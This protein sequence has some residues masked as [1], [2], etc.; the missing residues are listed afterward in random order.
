MAQMIIAREVRTAI[1]H[2][3]VGEARMVHVV[4]GALEKP[5]QEGMQ[6]VAAGTSMEEI[7][8]EYAHHFFS[9]SITSS[10]IKLAIIDWCDEQT[11][12]GGLKNVASRLKG[13]KLPFYPE[14]D[15]ISEIMIEW[16]RR[17][18][19]LVNNLGQAY[20]KASR[21]DPDLEKT[22]DFKR[23]VAALQE[24]ED[25][26]DNRRGEKVMKGVIKYT[27]RYPERNDGP[28]MIDGVSTANY[29]RGN[30]YPNQEQG[31]GN[32][33]YGGSVSNGMVFRAKDPSKPAGW[34][35]AESD[36][37]RPDK[38]FGVD[39]IVEVRIPAHL[40]DHTAFRDEVIK[41]Q[42][43][44]KGPDDADFTLQFN[45]LIEECTEEMP[46]RF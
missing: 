14:Q 2:S 7:W 37:T 4:R 39:K 30:S 17:L 12:L 36:P 31:Y 27:E 8:I 32:G 38:D 45:D 13:V 43:R 15:K 26:Y 9:S 25:V 28:L 11:S 33:N 42:R 5:R 6:L 44:F 35:T 16:L 18:I 20:I 23:L 41:L 1:M 34:K 21:F 10:T 19:R 24:Y 40:K 46:H 29:G 22:T 3:G